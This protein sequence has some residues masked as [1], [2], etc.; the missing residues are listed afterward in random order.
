MKLD[1]KFEETTQ[2][3][4]HIWQDFQQP[5]SLVKYKLKSQWD[6]DTYTTERIFKKTGNAK[7]FYWCG[8][9]GISYNINVCVTDQKPLWKTS[10][11]LYD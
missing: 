2:E 9:T 11:L 6:T 1:K 8:A 4:M 5:Y 3:N 10:D 7:Y